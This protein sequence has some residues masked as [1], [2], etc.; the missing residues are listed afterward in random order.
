[1]NSLRFKT[2]AAVCVSVGLSMVPGLWAWNT[3]G[4]LFG[5][6]AAQFKHAVAA[7][8]AA[9][10]LRL[11]LLPGRPSHYCHPGGCRHEQ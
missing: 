5:L 7:A 6:P 11:L 1:M 10:L 4:D 2:L 3:L 9:L 8:I